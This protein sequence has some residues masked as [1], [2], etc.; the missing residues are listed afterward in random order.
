MSLSSSSPE[1]CKLKAI[2]EQVTSRKQ[3]DAAFVVGLGGQLAVAANALIHLSGSQKKQ[4]VLDVVK[5]E[6]AAIDGSEETRKEL[7]FVAESVLPAC[8][9]LAVDAARGKLDLKKVKKSC[10]A[11]LRACLPF[12]ASAAA[13]SSKEAALVVRTVQQVVEPLAAAASVP[14]SPK[15][16]HATPPVESHSPKVVEQE[17]P[18]PQTN[19]EVVLEPREE[20]A[21]PATESEKL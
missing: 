9:D 12:A 13:A 17:S 19:P 18:P 10:F 8:L 11:A 6:V 7:L 4:L 14:E 20:Q 1:F 5:S 2:A 16:E 15:A 21:T 3:W